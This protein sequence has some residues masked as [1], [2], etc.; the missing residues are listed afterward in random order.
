[1]ESYAK[2]N[3]SPEVT[4][5]T[6]IDLRS[7]ADVNYESDT[8]MTVYFGTT[9]RISGQ[10]FVASRLGAIQKALPRDLSEAFE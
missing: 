10:S 2:V 5:L 6:D 3:E 7:L 4:S 1:M 9:G 8:F